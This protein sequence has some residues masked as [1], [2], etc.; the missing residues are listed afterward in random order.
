TSNPPALYVQGLTATGY[1]QA[2]LNPGAT[3]YW[4]VVAKNSSGSAPASSTFSFTTAGALPA[5]VTLNTPANGATSQ[6][7]TPTLTW[8]AAANATVYDLYLGTGNPP[9]VYAQN[10]TGT[11]Y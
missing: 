3:Y 1:S 4:N 8:S 6:S 7:G 11:S 9:A 5:Q 2:S 10:L